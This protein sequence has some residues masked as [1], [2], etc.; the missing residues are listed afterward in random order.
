VRKKRREKAYFVFVILCK[1]KRNLRINFVVMMECLCRDLSVLFLVISLY[2]P[3]S[4]TGNEFKCP[5][6]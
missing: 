2:F 6:D 3:M 5:F 1:K 4:F